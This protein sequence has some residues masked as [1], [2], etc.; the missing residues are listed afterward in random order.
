MVTP[1]QQ[2]PAACYLGQIVELESSKSCP[3]FMSSL[4]TKSLN[5]KTGFPKTR[6]DFS[7]IS[8]KSR[9]PLTDYLPVIY[10]LLPLEGDP[11]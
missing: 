4:I 8:K 5:L 10:L 9:L 7:V 6:L 2:G 3:L 1:W 11:G